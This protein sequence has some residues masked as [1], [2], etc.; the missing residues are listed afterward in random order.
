MFKSRK[1]KILIVDD[2]EDARKTIS[3]TLWDIPCSITGVGT[4]EEALALLK[5]KKFN[6]V[7]L[8]IR[9]PGINGIGVLQELRNQNLSL[10]PII[11]LTG[12]PDNNLK[13][14]INI[15][16]VSY[17]LTKDPLDAEMLIK[18]IKEILKL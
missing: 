4:G 11:V 18:S 17:Y 2:K 3:S 15:F 14:D 10:P 6:V 16:G 8:D 1:Y 9:L 5:K 7:I 13:N 12:S